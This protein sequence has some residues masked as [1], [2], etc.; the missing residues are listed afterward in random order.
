MV[1]TNSIAVKTG[2]IS[3]GTSAFAMIVLEN[4]LE[5]VYP[6][7]DIVTTPSGS[8]VAMVHTNNCTSDLNA[9]VNLFDELLNLLNISIDRKSTRLN[10]S[11]VSISYAVFC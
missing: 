1:A 5:D 2:N 7:I 9:W 11:H 8:E 4:S 3:A 10:S 6:E